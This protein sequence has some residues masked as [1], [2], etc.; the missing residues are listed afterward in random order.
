MGLDN[1]DRKA[2]Q[3]ANLVCGFPGVEIVMLDRQPT[4][5]QIHN[6]LADRATGDFIQVFTDD[7]EMVEANWVETTRRALAALPAGLG[8]SYP[9]DAMYPNFS[10]LPIV[11]RKTRDLAGYYLPPWFPFLFGDTWWNEVGVMSGMILPS[12]A[13]ARL[14]QETGHIHNFRNVKLWSTMFDRLR[15]TRE[16]L[17]I[18]MIRAAF[19]D[20]DQGD[21]MVATLPERSAMLTELHAPCMTEEFFHKWDNYG[22][23]FPHPHYAEIEAKAQSFMERI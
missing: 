22:D 3:A 1:D 8:I 23:G 4:V 21:Y 15:P 9:T 11:S 14:S 16:Q 19:A 2:E 6:R 7:Y 17:A 5:S 12:G 13:T 10:T 20:T 18:E